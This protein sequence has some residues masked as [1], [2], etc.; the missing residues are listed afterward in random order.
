MSC[1]SDELFFDN[2][3]CCYRFL[4]LFELF[5]VNFRHE[6]RTKTFSK[7]MVIRV[8]VH[9]CPW[10]WYLFTLLHARDYCNVLELL[11]T[12]I[13][14][15]TTLVQK[16]SRG[17]PHLARGEKKQQQ[18]TAKKHDHRKKNLFF[19]TVKNSTIVSRRLENG[20]LSTVCEI[21][22][23]IGRANLAINSTEN[24]TTTPRFCVCTALLFGKAPIYN[25]VMRMLFKNGRFDLG[26]GQLCFASWYQ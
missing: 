16:R 24:S 11:C 5:F 2:E 12:V 26:L 1:D 6:F 10:T 23:E 8:P 4:A 21:S 13:H 9:G 3:S 15:I 19:C 18:K 25:S 17:D 14:R 20:G 7:R 22:G